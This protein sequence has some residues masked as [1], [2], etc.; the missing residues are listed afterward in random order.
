[1]NTNVNTIIVVKK[2]VIEPA[3]HELQDKSTAIFEGLSKLKDYQATMAI[4]KAARPVYQK[5]YREL[6]RIQ[7]AINEELGRLESLDIIEIASGPH[8]WVSN[9]TATP[10]SIEKVRSCLHAMTINTAIK[11]EI[12]PI[13]ALESVLDIM[14]T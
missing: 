10:K 9:V 13:P 6:C 14:S 4:E 7:K 11:R 2:N 12:F 1:M 3:L 8:D 5:I